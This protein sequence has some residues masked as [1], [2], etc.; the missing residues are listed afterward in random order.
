MG[1]KWAD[2][3]LSELQERFPELR[4][5]RCNCRKISGTNIWSQ[6][7]WCNA[8]DLYH[9]D[10]GY[11]TNPTHQAWL[12]TVY[13]FII[14]YQD[15]L[16]IRTRIWRKKD[17]FNHIHIDPWP[18]G[19]RT[20]PCAGASSSRW[21]YPDRSGETLG[22]YAS[23]DPLNGYHELP[24]KPIEEV[25]HMNQTI[26]KGASGFEVVLVQ[27]ALIQLEYDLGN[28]APYE[29]DVPSWFNGEIPVGADGSFGEATRLAIVKFQED[30][31]LTVNG[32]VD[33]VTAAFLF[34][35]TYEEGPDTVAPH[36]HTFAGKTGEA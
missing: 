12:D 14:T 32:V 20:P 28:W 6:H 26:S 15:E 13:D 27:M 3:A 18:K 7:A 22:K 36:S 24:D 4:A 11:S 21:E 5:G 33:G 1:T 10:W 25:D 30:S 2:F 8:L 29:G 34:E 17:H 19:V 35:A 31:S 23:P 9:T 16:S